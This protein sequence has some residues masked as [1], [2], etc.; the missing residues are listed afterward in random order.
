MQSATIELK[1]ETKGNERNLEERD[2]ALY[3][4]ITP[5]DKTSHWL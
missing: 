3:G 2:L 1:E 4:R 5:K